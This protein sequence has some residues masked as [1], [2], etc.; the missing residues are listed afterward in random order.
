MEVPKGNNGCP[1]GFGGN[2]V[3]INIDV[4]NTIDVSIA[5]ML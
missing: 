1:H 2:P 5:C 4:V 3:I